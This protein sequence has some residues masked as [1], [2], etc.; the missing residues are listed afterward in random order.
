MIMG[1]HLVTRKVGTISSAEYLRRLLKKKSL[2][3]GRHIEIA[4]LT[5]ANTIIN[6]IKV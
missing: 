3:K 2:T 4:A 6:S 1:S 5:T